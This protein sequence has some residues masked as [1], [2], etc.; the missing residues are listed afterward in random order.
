MEK[1]LRTIKDRNGHTI[2]EAV[3]MQEDGM[4]FLWEIA[5]Y[6]SR[7]FNLGNCWCVSHPRAT[8][9]PIRTSEVIRRFGKEVLD[10]FDPPGREQLVFDAFGVKIEE[11][12][13]Y[14]RVSY[15]LGVNPLPPIRDTGTLVGLANDVVTLIFP[16]AEPVEISVKGA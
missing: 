15:R 14:L 10:G 3:L 13:A 11:L 12:E 7:L 6:S 1:T 8:E 4:L 2:R 9:V 16:N 5:C